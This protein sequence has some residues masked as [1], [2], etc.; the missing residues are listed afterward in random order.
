[1]SLLSC[2]AYPSG[3][4]TTSLPDNEGLIESG[5]DREGNIAGVMVRNTSSA[6]S[7]VTK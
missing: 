7:G 6:M 4:V 5:K 2:V 1:M 3:K